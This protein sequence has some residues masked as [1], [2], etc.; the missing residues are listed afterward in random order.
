MIS[1][2]RIIVGLIGGLV[3]GVELD[4]RNPVRAQPATSRDPSLPLV[5][6][7]GSASADSYSH[8][9]IALC[10]GLAAAGYVEGQNIA[11]EA[12]WADGSVER[13]PQFAAEFVRR[14]VKVIVASGSI[15]SAFAAK[16]ASNTVPIVFVGSDAD[17]FGLVSSLS[18]PGGNVTG[19]SLFTS[20]LV[21][22]RLELLHELVP[23]T[24]E[25]TVLVRVGSPLLESRLQDLAQ[26]AATMGVSLRIVNA[27]TEGELEGAIAIVAQHPPSA[28]YVMPGIGQSARGDE[29][30]ATLAARHGIPSIYDRRETVEAGGLISYGN[31]FVGAYHLAGTYVARILKGEQPAEMPMQ[32]PDKFELVVNLKTAKTLGIT[33]PQS[34]LLRADEVIE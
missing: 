30:I 8:L 18:R 3:G 24:S 17:K 15:A 21:P 4:W 9:V 7:L 10:N 27:A 29:P 5:G 26:A 23:S 28:L 22:K 2:R 13:L 33:V 19:V 31:S 25:I 20:T 32:Q 34:I 1:R 12:L 16:A 14:G 6:V 11:V